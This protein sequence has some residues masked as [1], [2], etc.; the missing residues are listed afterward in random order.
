MDSAQIKNVIYPF[1]TK[2][3]ICL[4]HRD[5]LIQK[6]VLYTFDR[7]KSDSFVNVCRGLIEKAKECVE[8]LIYNYDT[9]P[10]RI[11]IRLSKKYR[12]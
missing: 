3:C 9:K 1:R 2:L 11:H 6:H 10:K 12:S 7:H 5:R 4:K 8:D